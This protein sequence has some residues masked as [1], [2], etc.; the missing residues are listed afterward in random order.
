MDADREA[1]VI[2]F[3]RRGRL[4]IT[5]DEGSTITTGPGSVIVPVR[6]GGATMVEVSELL[7]AGRLVVRHD[8]R[9]REFCGL[10]HKKVE[11]A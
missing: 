2:D 11:V 3:A 9:S 4:Y 8:K 7:D 1:Q 5:V 6:Q 10:M